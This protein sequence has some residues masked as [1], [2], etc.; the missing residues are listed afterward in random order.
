[1][2]FPAGLFPL[3]VSL[4]FDGLMLL[5]LGV[6]VARV[7]WRRLDRSVLNAWLGAMVLVMVLWTLRDEYRPGISFHLLGMAILTLMMGPWLAM[8]AAALVMAGAELS[9]GG[10]LLPVGL[11]WFIC[12]AVPIM[13]TRGALWLTQRYLPANYFVYFF[14]NAFL[15]GGLSMTLAGL[16]GV[17]ALGIAGIHGWDVL[18]DEAMPYYFLL[19]WSEAFTTGLMMAILVVYRP[20][21]VCTFDD[22]RY[23]ADRDDEF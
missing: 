3:S 11:D 22:G 2:D 17:L 18:F 7:G 23:L 1:M 10:S 5:A 19:S 15:A 21:W 9:R 4:T 13:F 12:G 16:S 14:F 8:L 6:S 20:R